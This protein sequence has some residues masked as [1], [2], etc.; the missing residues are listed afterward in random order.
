M[1]LNSID[2][3]ELT[4][5]IDT[6]AQILKKME[7]MIMDEIKLLIPRVHSVINECQNRFHVNYN[8]IRRE[9]SRESEK[10]FIILQRSFEQ[11]LKNAKYVHSNN[12]ASYIASL[13]REKDE[14]L[15][16]ISEEIEEEEKQI[17]EEGKDEEDENE[18]GKDEENENKKGKDEED[19]NKEGKDEE[20]EN[21]EGKDEEDE[22]KEGKDE[23]DENKEG[24]DEEDE[25]KEGKDEEDENK[26]GKDE[27][28]ENKEGKDEE[29]EG[30]T[31]VENIFEEV[32]EEISHNAEMG[33]YQEEL[34]EEQIAEILEYF[35][36]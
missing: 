9:R 7:D 16:S 21:K 2:V 4:D 15:K 5:P 10:K 8:R 22:N 36:E 28:D 26:E 27:E 6:A 17:D 25:N 33:D 14:I 24:K 32:A 13:R 20:D 12:I 34:G 31:L 18:E 3:D 1:S 11:K 19:E 30:E 23:E 29:D 35:D